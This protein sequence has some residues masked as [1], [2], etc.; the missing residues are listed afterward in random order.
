VA[1]PSLILMCGLP[2]A[3]KTTEAKRLEVE[4]NA[5]RLSA[6]E[7]IEPLF[8]ARFLTEP[9]LAIN[10]NEVVHS[11][12]ERVLIDIAKRLIA[13][14]T[15]VILDFGVWARE[16]R[17]YHRA[18]AADLGAEVEIVLLDPP[19]DVILARLEARNAVLPPNTYRI[20]AERVRDWAGTFQRPITGP[21]MFEQLNHVLDVFVERNRALLGTNFV[22]AYLQGSFA[23]GGADVHSDVDFM[24][25]TNTELTGAELAAIDELHPQICALP[26]DWSR[27]LE[28]SYV[29]KDQLRR[30]DPAR[31]AWAYFD[32]GSQIL[33]RSN[34]DNTAVVRA[35]LRTH[36]ITLAGPA[37]FTLI[38]PVD[39]TLMRAEMVDMMR[40]RAD[41]IRAE[42]DQLDNAW[43][44]PHEVLH[45]CR[46][47]QTLALGRVESKASAGVWGREHLDPRFGPL[48]QQA[49]DQRPDP[50]GRVHRAVGDPRTVA[51]TLAFIEYAIAHVEADQLTG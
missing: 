8:G 13:I 40:E 7:L 25:V 31:G 46:I 5:I 11:A 26:S 17:D 6:D 39:P 42:P 38:D 21:T 4:R 14:G 32:N 37:P 20:H 30:I 22:G 51:E 36:G 49:L 34:H 43:R 10:D 3:G 29:P 47:L 45:F 2:C 12:V 16:E 50:W 23:V 41:W 28:G 15:S 9:D 18:W 24:I 27:H 35:T 19:L 1:R 44:Q 48:I 33:E